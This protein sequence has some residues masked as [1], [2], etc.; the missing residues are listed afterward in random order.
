MCFKKFVH[1]VSANKRE[2]L[3]SIFSDPRHLCSNSNGVDSIGKQFVSTM[4]P[5]KTALMVS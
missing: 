3:I 5:L 2:S 4:V 1:P